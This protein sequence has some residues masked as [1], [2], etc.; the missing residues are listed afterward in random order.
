MNPT[1]LDKVIR[2]LTWACWLAVVAIVIFSMKAKAQP[3]PPPP[4]A[5]ALN[6]NKTTGAITNNVFNAA[7]FASS[8]GLATT[9]GS[10]AS[11]TGTANQ[12]LANGA[13]SAQTGAVTLTIP[14][15]FTVPGSLTTTTTSTIGTSES[16]TGTAGAGF[17]QIANQ[18]SAPGTPTSAGRLYWDSSN[19]LSWKGTNGWVRTFDGTANNADQVYTLP[20]VSS[21][22]VMYANPS[23]GV[24]VTNLNSITSAA[25][26]ELILNAGA[27]DKNII[28]A[29]TGSGFFKI[30]AASDSDRTW[31]T[32]DTSNSSR[33]SYNFT[34]T[35]HTNT[36]ATLWNA[37]T[38][39]WSK[40]GSSPVWGMGMEY[41]YKDGSN[42]FIDEAYFRW[43][44]TPAGTEIRPLIL[45]YD[46][47]ASSITNTFRATTTYFNDYSD[48][49]RASLSSTGLALGTTS[50]GASLDTNNITFLK[51][52]NAANN[53]YYGLIYLNGSNAVVLGDGNTA[54]ITT[55]NNLELTAGAI[56]ISDMTLSRKDTNNF[57]ISSTAASSG[58]Y[59]T[60]S[61]TSGTEGITYENT[62]AS[63][64]AFSTGTGGSTMALTAIRSR[65]YLYDN[66]GSTLI[67]T[68]AGP[69]ATTGDFKIELSTEATTGGAAS[70]TSAGGIY[71]AKKIITA[72]TFTSAAGVTFDIGAANVVSPTS[73]NRTITVSIGGTTYYLAAKT[74]N[75]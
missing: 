31:M 3:P 25:S 45:A 7:L 28:V 35:A 74:T 11:I 43:I 18:S 50:Y 17:L 22:F 46:R 6:V 40:D 44:A 61:A 19:R 33:A 20:N 71:A 54:K 52:K 67:A 8:N 47:T 39:G 16:I 23:A 48:F 70:L 59:I 36:D 2:A 37:M 68:A 69:N 10:V 13:T 27:G 41:N 62:G 38:Y 42:H 49:T 72:S 15:A 32:F 65:W 58:L 64:R 9:S 55:A 21:T 60:N 29:P 34:Y 57:Q 51:Q 30:L 73:P 53:A 26:T 1:R 14:S 4:T 24:A 75:D 12:I 63:G 66:T 56:T 5:V